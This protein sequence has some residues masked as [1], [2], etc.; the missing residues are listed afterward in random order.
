MASYLLPISDRDALAWIL[1][2]ERTALPAHRRGDASRLEAGDRLLLYTTRGCF[3]NPT[4]DR[5]RV[6]GVATVA[7][8]PRDLDEP[9]HFGDREYAIGIDFQ[10]DVLLPRDGGVEL[11]PL[12]PKLRESFPNQ[13]AWSARLR[14]ALVPVTPRDAA[15]LERQLMRSTA[16]RVADAVDTYLR[17]ATGRS[18]GADAPAAQGSLLTG[19]FLH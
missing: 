13:R 5:G 7:R 1:R 8:E 3:R 14:R 17:S 4:R 11:A 10:L 15:K 18:A 19:R 2:E 16:P 12:V 9:V 6:I